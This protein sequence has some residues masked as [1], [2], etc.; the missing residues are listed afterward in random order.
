MRAVEVVLLLTPHCVHVVGPTVD[1]NV[2]YAHSVN[3]R[4]FA[5][6][7]PNQTERACRMS[8]SYKRRGDGTS[9][10]AARRGRRPA[11]DAADGNT[12]CS[13]GASVARVADTRGVGSSECGWQV[14]VER[15]LAQARRRRCIATHR[16]SSCAHAR[17]G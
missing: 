11:A 5:N 1:L 16:P 14:S 12:C 15:C 3:P 13:Q 9:A 7:G 17:L 2:P 10:C 4:M 6:I 8:R